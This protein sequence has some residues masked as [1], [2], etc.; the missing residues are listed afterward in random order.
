MQE[1]IDYIEEIVMSLVYNAAFGKAGGI[2]LY[3]RFRYEM[4][5]DGFDLIN[6]IIEVEN[7]FGIHITDE[8][9]DDIGTPE[10]L[11]NLVFEKTR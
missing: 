4:G 5:L 2:N 3:S 1:E 7:E 9:F 11:I 6:L 10:D 8:E